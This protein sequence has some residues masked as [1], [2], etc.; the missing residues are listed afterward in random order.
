MGCNVE[1]D[2]D[3]V[4]ENSPIRYILECDLAYCK[5]LHDTHS[6]YPLCPEK[7]EASSDILSSYCRD[8]AD[9]YGIKIGGVKKLIPSLGDKV[10]YIVH[11]K[12]LQYLLSMRMK[13]V[14]IDRILRMLSSI[15]RKD[16][17][18]LTNLIKIF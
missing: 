5:K 1:N 13:L 8:I 18:V 10:K 2:R 16:K 15:L 4:T 3:K 17:K 6:D 7:I 12:N 9:Q 11:Y 14:K